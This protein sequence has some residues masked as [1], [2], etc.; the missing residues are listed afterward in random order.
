PAGTRASPRD[1]NRGPEAFASQAAVLARQKLPGLGFYPEERRA[2][3]QGSVAAQVLGYVG[4]DDKG[5]AG[6]EFQ[7]DRE[8]AGKTGHET[9]VKDP[10]G[11]AIDV[12]NNRPEIPGRDVT[13]T[14]DHTIQ[15]N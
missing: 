4:V 8:L 5:L 7:L 3:P 10:A 11:R 9:I 13:I 6:L 14:I 15:A 1:R 12:V 2:Y